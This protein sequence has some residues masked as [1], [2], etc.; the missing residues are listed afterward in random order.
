MKERKYLN[1]DQQNEV[2]PK[3]NKGYRINI[4]D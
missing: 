4:V 1:L 3:E 2:L